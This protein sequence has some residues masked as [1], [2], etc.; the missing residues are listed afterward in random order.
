MNKRAKKI[1]LK[2]RFGELLN[3]E[4]FISKFNDG[5]LIFFLSSSKQHQ[6]KVKIITMTIA[7]QFI[8]SFIFEINLLKWKEIQE[9]S[10][11]KIRNLLN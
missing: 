9:N 1:F 3:E 5:K 7:T 2:W 6:Q 10:A 4:K 11:M 8:I